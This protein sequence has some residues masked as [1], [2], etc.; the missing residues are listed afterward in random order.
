[1]PYPNSLWH[2]D[3]YHKL[4]RWRILIHGGVDGYSRIPVY[5]V[6]S[7]NNRAM[8]VLDA[9]EG[10]VRKYGLP[11]RIRSDRGGENILV[12]TLMLERRGP[13]RGSMI[14]GKSVH[15]QRIELFWRDMF[16]G[17]V[18]YFYTLFRHLEESGL[19]M[20]TI[21]PTCFLCILCSY[22]PLI[23]QSLR[24]FAECWCHH[25]IRTENNRTPLQLW[26]SGSM[27]RRES[28]LQD[29]YH[30][31]EVSSYQAGAIHIESNYYFRMK[32]SSMESTGMKLYH[33]RITLLRFP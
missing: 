32:L 30:L 14:T 11:S 6:A 7:D 4:I 26:I 16:M 12:A 10:A 1:M 5:L 13:G 18:Y 17:C 2:I 9:F 22:I 25:K 24:C 21:L 20:L 29:D 31:S 27:A 28:G 33:P 8:T 15:N 19:W 23:N 3:G